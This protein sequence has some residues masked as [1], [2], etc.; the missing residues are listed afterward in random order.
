MSG[1]GPPVF[2]ASGGPTPRGEAKPPLIL[3]PIILA[4]TALGARCP[5]PKMPGMGNDLTF[6]IVVVALGTLPVLFTALAVF[7]G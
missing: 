2:T 5:A 7:G 4:Q 6:R 3:L 1:T